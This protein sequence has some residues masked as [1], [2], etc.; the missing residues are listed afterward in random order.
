MRSV[1]AV[2]LAIGA[3]QQFDAHARD[4]RA[5]AEFLKQHPCPVTGK[6]R[7]ACPGF[8]VDHVTP[9]CAGGADAPINMQWQTVG[10][11]KEKDKEEHALCRT[12]RNR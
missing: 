7:G 2:A 12:L 3:L 5:R 9:L 8:V 1:I 10:E 11:A 6:S 4:P